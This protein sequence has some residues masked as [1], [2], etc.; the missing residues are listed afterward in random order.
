MRKLSDQ[1]WTKIQKCPIKRGQNSIL[2]RSKSGILILST[3]QG[4][5]NIEIVPLKRGQNSIITSSNR[6][7]NAKKILKQGAKYRNC[8]IMKGS[9]FPK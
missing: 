5:F 9:K 8:P 7:Q 6:G 4:D 2:L 1:K 3:A